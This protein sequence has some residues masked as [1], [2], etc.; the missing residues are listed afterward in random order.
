M[1][2]PLK[3]LTKGSV[4]GTGDEEKFRS[5]ASPP[6]AA[7]RAQSGSLGNQTS[8]PRLMLPGPCCVA[9]DKSLT[10]LSLEFPV[11]KRELS[12]LVQLQ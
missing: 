11:C 4:P 3:W 7:P 2:T 10:L 1:L 5:W 8:G 12:N 6:L 9:S